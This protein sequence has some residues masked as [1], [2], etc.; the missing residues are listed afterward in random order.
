MLAAVMLSFIS[1]SSL[2]VMVSP[3]SI[4]NINFD[5]QNFGASQT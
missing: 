1:A 5:V 4:I 3:V 2:I